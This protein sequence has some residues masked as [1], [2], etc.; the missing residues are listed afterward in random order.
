MTV[1]SF[2]LSLGYLAATL[3]VIMVVPQILRT[4]RHPDLGGVSPVAWSLTTLGCSTWL[5]Y[6]LRTQTVQQIPGNALLVCGAVAVVLLVPSQASRARRALTLGAV[7]SVL[8]SVAVL[9]PAH[10][11][12]YLAVSI[13]FVAAWPQV[14]DSVLTWRSGVRSGVSLT[15]WAL[16]AVSQLCWL[17]YA[18]AA[19]DLP[20]MLASTFA[21]S[22]AVLLVTL[23][24]SAANHGARLVT[25]EA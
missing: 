20:V 23:E 13:G 25:A 1:H 19:G 16:K 6:G 21:L 2:A 12:G 8:L 22:T 3:G 14:F 11:V 7:A 24:A 18:V 17:T 9:L 4:V 15:T 10:S 5:V